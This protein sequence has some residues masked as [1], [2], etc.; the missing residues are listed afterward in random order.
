MI[1]QCEQ[2]QTKFKLDDSKVAD[3][4]I[5]VRCARCRHVFTVAPPTPAEESTAL[6]DETPLIAEEREAEAAGLETAVE[7]EP[8]TTLAVSA[9][10]ETASLDTFAF[11]TDEEPQEEKEEAAAPFAE[12]ETDFTFPSVETPAPVMVEEEKGSD[13]LDFGAFD[14][15]DDSKEET[16]AAP[17]VEEPQL[18]MPSPKKEVSGLDFSD[19]DMFG[20]IST[21]TEEEEDTLSFD[22]GMDDFAD[23]IGT[24]VAPLDQNVSFTPQEK[25]AETPFSLDDIDFGDEMTSVAVQQVSPDELQPTKDILFTPIAPSEP[26]FSA[27]AFEAAA[28]A[29]QLEEP[30]APVSRLK[31]KPRLSGMLLMLWVMIISLVVFYAV[32]GFKT[33]TDKGTEE[34]ATVSQDAGRISVRGVEATYVKNKK[35]G[36]LLVIT[37]EAVNEYN[38]P[39][40]AIQVKGLVFGSNGDEIVS[41]TAFCGNPLTNEQLSTMTQEK[42]EAA[43]ANQF[44]DSLAN[45]EVAPGSTIPFVIVI[46]SPPAGATDY[47]VEPAGSTVA[48]A[49]EKDK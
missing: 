47:G 36:N 15:G 5:K 46:P 29:P 11:D 18:S 43:M 38:K 13:D 44:G 6:W 41:K 45:M 40:A 1:I 9:S 27:E 17:A 8:E 25:G 42:I 24:D 34:G 4:S 12:E 32:W 31:E 30:A 33:L 22:M 10:E 37:G 49:K 7:F 48:S 35:L 19:D 3:K 2:C 26:Q 20:E 14:F 28:P 21:A 39:R 16:P 23:S